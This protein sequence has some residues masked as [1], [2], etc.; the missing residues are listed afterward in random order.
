MMLGSQDYHDR[1][2][3]QKW[4]PFVSLSL[5]RISTGSCLSEEAFILVIVSL[6]H[7]F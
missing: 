3:L 2:G 5:K 4:Y 7:V 6:S 1:I